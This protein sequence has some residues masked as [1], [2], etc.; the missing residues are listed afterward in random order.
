MACWR[1]RMDGGGMNHSTT[2]N[3][4]PIPLHSTIVF[5]CFVGQTEKKNKEKKRKQRNRFFSTLEPR[6]IQAS[7]NAVGEQGI[8]RPSHPFFF[9][10]SRN[11]AQ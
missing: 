9:F 1:M 3:V 4:N 5:C 8:L 7:E 10:Y 6:E 2:V 11:D